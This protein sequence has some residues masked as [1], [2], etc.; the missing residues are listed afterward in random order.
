VQTPPSIGAQIPQLALQ[1]YVPATHTLPPHCT[2]AG[3]FVGF[4][5]KARSPPAF[6][7]AFTAMLETNKRVMKQRKRNMMVVDKEK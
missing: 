1:Q 5:F 2:S 3:G 7:S 6:W 4:P